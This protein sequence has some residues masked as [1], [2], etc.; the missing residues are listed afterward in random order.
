MDIWYQLQVNAHNSQVFLDMIQ[1]MREQGNGVFTATLK[2]NDSHIVD[3]VHVT[4]YAQSSPA[5]P[6]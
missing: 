3:Y 2:L 5:V 6:R 4:N 1:D